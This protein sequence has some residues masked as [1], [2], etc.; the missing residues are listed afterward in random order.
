VIQISEAAF[1]GGVTVLGAIITW[2]VRLESRLN[3][4]L[5]RKEHDEICKGRNEALEKK[6]D[7]I[8]EQ[9][10]QQNESTLQHRQWVGD[11]L[12]TI[13]T[14]VALIRDRMGDDPFK[15][16]TGTY[17]RGNRS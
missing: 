2:L 14:H 5:T 4:R 13:R 9:I 7:T 3:A 16:T 17:S 12:G 15:D 11:S 1:W 10:R 8:S 6:L